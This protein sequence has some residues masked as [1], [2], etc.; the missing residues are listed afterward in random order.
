MLNMTEHRATIVN[1]G[2][3]LLILLRQIRPKIEWGSRQIIA[4]VEDFSYKV[5]IIIALVPIE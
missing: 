2:I 5:E 4:Y 3:D 1:M